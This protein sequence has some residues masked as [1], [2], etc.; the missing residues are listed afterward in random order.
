[1]STVAGVP[2]RAALVDLGRAKASGQL[3][4]ADQSGHQA[5]IHFREGF[6]TGIQMPDHRPRI[7]MRLVAAGMISPD[8]LATALHLQQSETAANRTG[9]PVRIGDVLVRIGAVGRGVVEQIAQAQLADNLAGLMTWQIRDTGFEPA[10]PSGSQSA[11]DTPVEIDR[12]LGAADARRPILIELV[13]RLG[14]PAAVPDLAGIP[15]VDPH[16]TLGPHDWALL[17]K[18]DGQRQLGELA[19]ACGYTTLEAAQILDGLLSVGLITIGRVGG[20]HPGEQEEVD[21]AALLRELSGI[22]GGPSGAS[23]RRSAGTSG[24]SAG[25]NRPPKKRGGLFSR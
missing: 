6:V 7:G 17:C 1:M 24:Q 15:T 12:L 13:R 16:P 9:I 8:Q 18:I 20:A 11:G 22:A 5:R 23:R 3:M 25:A 2:L 14:G 19:A 4:L 21:T 10:D